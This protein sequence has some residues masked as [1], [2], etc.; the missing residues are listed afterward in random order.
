MCSTTQH[1]SERISPSSVYYCPMECEGE[2]VYFQPGKRCS[3]CNMFLVPIEE[4]D[5][6]KNKPQ[7]YSKT[8]LPESFHL[9][10]SDYYCPMFCQGEATYPSDTG[11]PI[12]HMHLEEITEELLANTPK[13]K[14]TE[15][16][17]L[18]S[19][20]GKYYCPMFCEGDKVYDKNV[21]CPVCGMDLVQIASKNSTAIGDDTYSKLKKKFGYSL[22]FAFPLLI[23][24]MGGM[25]FDLPLSSAVSGWIQLALTL[26]ILF[27]FGWFI[28]KRG[29]ISFKT[30]NLNMFSLIALGVAAAFLF[31]IFVLI[32]P[33]LVPHQF[34]HGGDLPLYFESVGVILT[35]VIL[36]Q[37]M[38][39]KAHHQTSKSLEELLNLSPE[40]A[41]VIINSIEKEIPLDEVEVG[42]I[43]KVKP[44]EKIPVDG[45]ITDGTSSIDESMITGEPIPTEKAKGDYV[46]SGTLNGDG[47]FLM[48]AEKVGEATLL[49]QIIKMVTEA[50]R[51]KAPL[52][53]MVDKVSKIF[54]PAVISVAILTFI[55]W[56][57]FGGENGLSF[58]FVNAIAV[59]IVACPCALGLATPM[60]LMVG[61]GKGAKNG[62]LVKNADALEEMNKVDVVITDKTGTLT[63][64]KP[65][66][67]GYEVLMN[68]SEVSK[69]EILQLAS[70][71]NQGSN[72]PLSKAILD[73]YHRQEQ[74]LPVVSDFKNISGKGLSGNIN[75]HE[76]LVG[77]ESLLNHYGT[78]VPAESKHIIS[79]YKA[80]TYSF[81]AKNRKAIGILFFSD[82]IKETSKFTVEYLQRK[83]IEVIM[84][85]GDNEVSARKVA[86][87]LE[88][89][90][91]RANCLPED[92]MKEIKKLQN[93]GRI[94]AMTGD[95]I[96][97]APA[98]AQ[99]NVGIAMG[100]GSDSAIEAAG[101][102]LLKG[103]ILGVAKAQ[104]LS[105]KLVKNIKENLF[106][107]F[108]YNLLGIPI[109]AGILYPFFGILMNPMLAAAAMSFS[110]LGVILNS[111]RLSKADLKVK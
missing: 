55:I 80:T 29:W 34:S 110:S 25:W 28:M 105:G 21:G 17:F 69:E 79:K 13:P 66:L 81:V 1:P 18:T 42:A 52:Q 94:V 54:V 40:K 11:C 104:I 32:F 108:I 46:T 37:M 107:A 51:S 33:S 83:N 109:A 73:V 27:Y 14:I 82:T 70:A 49:S 103:D 101:I 91:Y 86:S 47:L 56:A 67:E 65:I 2:K 102:T 58:G 68:S 39:A 12:C 76:I 6:Y 100:T 50:S 71:L 111:L 16:S 23:L 4:K 57:I 3:V 22:L 106:F 45:I 98:L 93:Q 5:E 9:H 36:G 60:S 74:D 62:I 35:L 99:A 63:Q 19:N 59:L 20:A 78:V 44:G 48:K 77:N 31:S 87:E 64:G 61:I 15:K 88:I 85:T 90:N 41:L 26:P 43:L 72:H 24:G 30:W 8:N 7:T 96:N 97:D 53:K 75:G 92:K 10:I 89:E 95:G 84:L 38:E